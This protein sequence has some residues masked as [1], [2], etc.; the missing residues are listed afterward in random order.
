VAAG[1]RAGRAQGRGVSCRGDF[2][3]RGRWTYGTARG[4]SREPGQFDLTSR[5]Q[6]SELPRRRAACILGPRRSQD[7]SRPSLSIFQRPTTS[8]QP[9]QTRRLTPPRT[10]RDARTLLQTEVPRPGNQGSARAG[11]TRRSLAH[12]DRAEGAADAGP[13]GS[14]T[15][16]LAKPAL[17]QGRETW[18]GSRCPARPPPSKQVD[19][20]GSTAQELGGS[21]RSRQ[22]LSQLQQRVTK[23]RRRRSFVKAPQYTS[24][25]RAQGG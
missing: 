9:R 3:F 10:R 25:R 2:A 24:A 12:A 8:S 21:R 6:A 14:L 17:G 23:F 13:H 19:A 18:P 22:A 15:G 7:R 5:V 16:D 1:A 4:P 11:R 20:A